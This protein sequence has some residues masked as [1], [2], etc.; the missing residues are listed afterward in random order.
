VSNAHHQWVIVAN[1][2]F[3]GSAHP[4]DLNNRYQPDI[5]FVFSADSNMIVPGD[6]EGRIKIFETN[7]ASIYSA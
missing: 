1:S 6:D 3:V 4:T 7:N 2:S 5:N